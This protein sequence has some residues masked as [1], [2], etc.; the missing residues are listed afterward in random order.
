MFRLA[1]PLDLFQSL[2]VINSDTSEGSIPH[3]IDPVIFQNLVVVRRL[4][5]EASE[6]VVK[7]SGFGSS[8]QNFSSSSSKISPMRQHRFREMAVQKLATAYKIDEIATSV[9][10]MQ[11]ASALDDVAF[12]VLRE[13]K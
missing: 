11:S 6:L 7:A 9:L 8:S 4:V 12:K 3:P 10:T 5:D 1:L 13:I 2:L